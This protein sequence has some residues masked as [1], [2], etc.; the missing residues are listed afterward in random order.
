MHNGVHGSG[1]P[2]KPLTAPLKR[3]HGHRVTT[4]SIGARIR[5]RR[6]EAKLSMEALARA[7]RVS[8]NTVARWESGETAPSAENLGLLSQTL[9]VSVDW[10][11]R[12]LEAP[13]PRA[14]PADDQVRTIVRSYLDGLDL[15]DAR[16]PDEDEQRWLE[17]LSFRELRG[18]G[19]EVTVDL[20]DRLLRERRAQGA[21]KVRERPTIEPP[22]MRK[23]RRKVDW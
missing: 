18:A 8:K 9:A 17:G 1:Y 20:L 6:R 4:G 22:P 11:V 23:G 5:A 13:A 19:L 7:V 2:V 15:D 10:L 16:R 14:E 21:R 12:G 3:G